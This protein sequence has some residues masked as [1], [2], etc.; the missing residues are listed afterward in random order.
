[1]FYTSL[2]GELGTAKLNGKK[3]RLLPVAKGRF[4]GIAYEVVPH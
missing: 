3:A 1:M 4:T 2:A